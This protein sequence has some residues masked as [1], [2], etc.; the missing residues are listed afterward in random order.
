MVSREAN[1]IRLSARNYRRRRLV[2]PAAL[3]LAAL[4]LAGIGCRRATTT[5]TVTGEA[6]VGPSRVVLYST[7]SLEASGIYELLRDAYQRANPQFVLEPH[8][9]GSGEA[10]AA[11]EQGL[12][13]VV[14]AHDPKKE[15]EVVDKGVIAQHE[16]V[17]ENDFVIIGPDADP[18]RLKG[19]SA[20]DAFKALAAWAGKLPKGRLG[21]VSRGQE[22]GTLTKEFEA[23]EAAGVER[24]DPNADA[25]YVSAGAGMGQVLQLAWQKEAYTLSDRG[26][27]LNLRKQLPGAAVVNEGDELY[28]NPYSVLV[29]DASRFPKVKLNQPGAQAFADFLTSAEGQKLIEGFTI[30]GE[31]LF[32]ATARP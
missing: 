23:W 17:M 14:L 8:F 15:Q 1:P 4:L 16:P 6:G 21:F 22:S 19:K 18:A 24:P 28:A 12:A 10:L 27:W 31:P 3:V 25:W 20:A 13:D 29:V 7:T 11:A 9:V 32:T 5:F 2:A 26:T 30:D